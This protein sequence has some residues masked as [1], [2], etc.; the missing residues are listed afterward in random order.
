MKALKLVGR[1]KFSYRL[2]MEYY[3]G[4]LHWVRQTYY[5]SGF[6]CQS[7]CNSA[8]STLCLHCHIDLPL[9]VQYSNEFIGRCNNTLYLFKPSLCGDCKKLRQVV[10][11]ESCSF[12]YFCSSE[13]DGRI[14]RTH[15]LVLSDTFAVQD[16]TVLGWEE[17]TIKSITFP[18][19]GLSP[20]KGLLLPKGCPESTE[21]P[22][23]VASNSA[24][25][26]LY[27]TCMLANSEISV[28]RSGV[29][30]S[31][32]RKAVSGTAIYASA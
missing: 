12:K 31:L 1:T 19:R 29:T 24:S 14:H 27:C 5:N 15:N 30:L 2:D 28:V 8:I 4:S 3:A 21:L 22:C 18:W 25:T 26:S 20:K 11:T 10:F 13:C 9:L 32:F 16:V 7:F 17:A 23:I 6:Y